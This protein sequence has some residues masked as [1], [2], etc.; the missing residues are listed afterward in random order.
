MKSSTIALRYSQAV[1]AL[2]TDR[3]QHEQI[4]RELDRVAAVFAG[5]DE[6]RALSRNPKFSV[7]DRKAIVSELLKRLMV[8]PITRNFVML[9]T[10]KGRL[11]HIAEI[12]AA[13]HD[14]ADSQAGRIRAQVTV[15]APLAELEAARLRTV[16]QKMTGKQVVL[17]Q[18]VDPSI[19]GG[20]VTRVGGRIYDGSVRAQLESLRT[21]LRS[22]AA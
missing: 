16:L 9:I 6:L 11:Q 13:Y 3:K 10:E 7:A 18:Q 22:P 4:G 19:I 17:E 20:V 2:A 1:L 21:R 14:Q 8:S 12:V 15:V 5:L